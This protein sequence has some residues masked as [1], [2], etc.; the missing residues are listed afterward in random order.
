MLKYR[1]NVLDELKKNGY[2]TNRLRKEKIFGESTISRIREGKANISCDSIGMI[3]SMLR[4][5]PGDILINEI[6]DEEKIKLF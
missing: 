6:T 4:C 2:N 1:I 3:C 5:Q